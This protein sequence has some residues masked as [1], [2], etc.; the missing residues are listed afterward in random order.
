MSTP[1]FS[2]AYTAAN[3]I[4]GDIGT[5]IA[6]QQ[7]PSGHWLSVRFDTPAAVSFIAVIN[8]Q[9]SLAY[10]IHCFNIW[11]GDSFAEFGTHCGG[12]QCYDTTQPVSVPF[13]VGCDGVVAEYVTLSRSYCPMQVST[14]GERTDELCA[15][16]TA[17]PPS[18]PQVTCG[19][20]SSFAITS[21]GLQSKRM[22]QHDSKAQRGPGTMQVSTQGEREGELCAAAT[23]DTDARLQMQPQPCAAQAL[24]L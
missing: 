21:D 19:D 9:D 8:R 24:G 12:T 5:I 15:A 6:T 11:L 10:F 22:W 20:R 2:A 1:P 23:A 18:S 13:M 7:G 16:G 14:Q 17:P 3:A 4:D